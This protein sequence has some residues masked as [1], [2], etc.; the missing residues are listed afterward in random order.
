[1]FLLL[2]PLHIGFYIFVS[3]TFRLYGI[4]QKMKQF[5]NFPFEITRKLIQIL[6]FSIFTFHKIFL[7]SQV[8]IGIYL[9][10][11]GKLLCALSRYVS[12]SN[13]QTLYLAY[14]YHLWFF[15]TVITK[16]LMSKNEYTRTWNQNIIKPPDFHP[17]QF[18]VNLISFKAIASVL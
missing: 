11:I 18:I 13:G 6:V 8:E 9:K 14:P 5:L 3:R 2:D 10:I 15:R 1:M 16:I 7:L 4:M 12:Q 17:P